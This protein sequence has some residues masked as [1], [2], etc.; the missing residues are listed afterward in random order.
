MAIRDKGGP[1]LWVRIWSILQKLGRGDAVHFTIKRPEKGA[2]F[3]IDTSVKAKY[4]LETEDP[5]SKNT[6]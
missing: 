4:R 3:I 6:V 5:I 2:G 1:S